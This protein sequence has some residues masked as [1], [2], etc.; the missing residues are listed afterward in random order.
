MGT[1]FIDGRSH[2]VILAAYKI[3]FLVTGIV[4]TRP[5]V[6]T[7]QD[8]PLMVSFHSQPKFTWSQRCLRC[9]ES[10]DNLLNTQTTIQLQPTAN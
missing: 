9:P 7:L 6:W 3:G 10:E 1:R 5:L 2:I 4:D 8:I